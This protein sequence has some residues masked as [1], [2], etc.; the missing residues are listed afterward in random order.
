MRDGF[1]YMSALLEGSA[2]ANAPR[3]SRHLARLLDSFDR[4]RSKAWG[5]HEELRE[6]RTGHDGGDA[7]VWSDEPC[8]GRGHEGCAPYHAL[9]EIGNTW[10]EALGIAYPAPVA[11]L[12]LT[13]PGWGLAATR[14]ATTR[15]IRCS[16]A[17]AMLPFACGALIASGGAE[18]AY[19]L[20]LLVP[21]AQAEQAERVLLREWRKRVP[22]GWA[23]R[24]DDLPHEC[25]ALEALVELRVRSEQALPLLA[26][27]QGV[28]LPDAVR[29]YARETG[30]DSD[31]E[32]GGQLHRIVIGSGLRSL[33]RDLQKKAKLA[34]ARAAGAEGLAMQGGA[35]EEDGISES[36]GAG[37]TVTADVSD[38]DA[39]WRPCPWDPRLEMRPSRDRRRGPPRLPWFVLERMARDGLAEPIIVEGRLIGYRTRPG[40][41]WPSGRDEGPDG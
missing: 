39:D 15:L 19:A 31:S 8:D 9:R 13:A 17:K 35:G 10:G 32:R 41:R 24:L 2:T 7:F 27:A 18:S 30:I 1:D 16:A 34:E 12:S 4:C 28:L 36:V 5:R 26:A 3:L 29:L 11:V 40:M 23:A 38:E 33:R 6:R 25:T 37:D 20:H 22:C 21:V 14:E